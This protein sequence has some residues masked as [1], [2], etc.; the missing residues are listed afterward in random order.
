MR[1]TLALLACLLCGAARAQPA[2]EIRAFWV[3]AFNPGA[4][5][6]SEIDL[7]L[8]RVRQTNCNAVFVQMRKGADAYYL[9]RYD[10]W[11]SNSKRFDALA[12]LIRQ[13]HSSVPRIQVHAWLNTF[14]VGKTRGNP[15]H[16]AARHP[17]WLSMSDTG[18]SYDNEATKVDP[19]HPGASD[20]TARVYLD[21]L[22]HYDV[23]G[24]HFDFVRYGSTGRKGNWGYNPASVARFNRRF[25]RTGKPPADDPEWMQWRRDQVTQFVRRVYA[26]A[27]R[28]K[29]RAMI[30]A[31]TITWQNGPK[32][33]AEYAAKTA[34][35]TRVFQDWRAWMQEGILDL[36]CQMSYF[37]EQR[38]PDYFR[39]WTA[40]GRANRYGRWVTAGIGLWM[41]TIAGSMRQIRTALASVR[42][43]AAQGVLL[44]SYAGTNANSRGSEQ[45][46]DEHLYSA[47][48]TDS[49]NALPAPFARPVAFP[50]MPWKS[51]P[52]TG[53]VMG[54]A[55]AGP[56]LVPADGA[57]IVLSG[58]ET[59]V[60]RADA[61]G[62][63]A[64]VGLKPGWYRVALESSGN[65]KGIMVQA[66]A[67]VA[68]IVPT[69]LGAPL[70]GLRNSVEDAYLAPMGSRVALLDVETIIG[71]DVTENVLYVSSPNT[72]DTLRVILPDSPGIAI[73]QGDRVAVMGEVG[74]VR[75]ER[76][77]LNAKTM[78]LGPTNVELDGGKRW[79]RIQYSGIVSRVSADSITVKTGAGA[80]EVLLASRKAPGVEDELVEAH[81]PEMGARVTVLG[82]LMSTADA[83]GVRALRLVP[84]GPGDIVTIGAPVKSN[85]SLGLDWIV[86][87][88]LVLVILRAVF[89]GLKAIR[90][91]RA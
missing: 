44:Y 71:T 52:K 77:L 62:F 14:A 66:K 31:A 72:G 23:D 3:D 1:W 24:V 39:N 55:V 42:A 70:S 30:S 38:H 82:I 21:V 12:Y 46:Y 54:Y 27:Q 35:M 88:L 64:F 75:G 60:I 85:P 89:N 28:V 11:A 25:G 86:V 49:T 80:V 32:S 45:N 79:R 58:P 41:N 26:Q 9:S 73:Q 43:G 37:S 20:W 7:L 61:L 8:K 13:A 15:M 33:R 50:A 29:P 22:R 34:G 68:E 2:P 87:A 91:D 67:G 17:D 65:T 57:R 18:E 10:P 56:D 47:L 5:S 90:S 76:A 6:A 69:L 19:G 40:F 84:G 81:V 59:R 51:S 53:T 36:N 83:A 4:R 48:A 16:I 63:Y 74:E 78:Y